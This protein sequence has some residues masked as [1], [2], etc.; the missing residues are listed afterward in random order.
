MAP[1]NEQIQSLRSILER[2]TE[3]PRHQANAQFLRRLQALQR[4]EV[5]DIRRRHANAASAHDEYQRILDFYLAEL[6]TGLPLDAMIARGPQGLEHT[7]RMNKGFS[8]FAN[9]MEY[10]VLSAAIQDRLTEALGNQP[11]TERNYAQALQQCE[12]AAERQRRLALLVE[13]GHQAAPHLR[14][15]MIYTGFKLLK[16]MFRS[17]GLGDLYGS[18]DAGFK[19]LRGVS[20]TAQMLATLADLE[21]QQLEVNLTRQIAAA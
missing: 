19:Q 2:Y 11:L 6:H 17:V 7:R 4:W 9:A 20:R 12:D 13:L 8:L 3:L 5:V 14:S 10:S 21:Q 15:R 1:T 16:A 18:M